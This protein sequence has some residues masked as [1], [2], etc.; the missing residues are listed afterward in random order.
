MA[1]TI[2]TRKFKE[3]KMKELRNVKGSYRNYEYKLITKSPN[4]IASG[5]EKNR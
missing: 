2:Q 1:R 5:R 4:E 3:G